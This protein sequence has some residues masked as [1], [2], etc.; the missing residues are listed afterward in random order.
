MMTDLSPFCPLCAAVHAINLL[1]LFPI[2]RLTGQP[3]SHSIRAVAGAIR[4]IATGRTT[5]PVAARWKVVGFVTSGL[6]AVVIYQW[7]F[8]EF[9]SRT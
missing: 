9:T 1:L 6:M 3:V 5:D 4:Y 8:V 7:V 2:M